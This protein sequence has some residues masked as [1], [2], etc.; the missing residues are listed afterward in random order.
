MPCD[1]FIISKGV[2]VQ[3]NWCRIDTQVFLQ[4]FALIGQAQT[5]PDTKRVDPV[6]VLE[7]S[8]KVFLHTAVEVTPSQERVASLR[9][10]LSEEGGWGE[11]R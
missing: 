4:L 8:K 7:L 11:V 3:G 1:I 5:L 2:N 6:L 9:E 10:Y